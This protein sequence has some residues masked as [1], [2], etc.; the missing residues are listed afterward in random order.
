M[1]ATKGK[2]PASKATAASSAAV[3]T[4]QITFD[5]MMILFAS[6][7]RPYCDVGILK[8]APNHEA[9]LLITKIPEFGAPQTLLHLHG[10][11]F[12]SRMWLDAEKLEAGITLFM[13]HRKPFQRDAHDN[14]M[15]FRWALDFEGEEMYT[16]KTSVDPSGFKTFLRIN[17]G[18]FYTQ[19]ISD[20]ELIKKPWKEPD[21]TIGRVAIKLR[22]EITL[23]D[24]SAYFQNGVN[25]QPVEIKAEQ[26][27]NYGIYVSQVRD[28]SAGHAHTASEDVDAENYNYVIAFDQPYNRKIHF[29]ATTARIDPDARCLIPTMSQSEIT[30]I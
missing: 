17:D 8:Y 16:V 14:P 5:G 18:T 10:E 25:A 23:T 13:D 27:V 4:V 3:S 22:A 1:F 20:N 9:N 19:S 29:G 21:Q 12:E 7:D 11:E 24:E 28:H 6:S 15:D 30:N 26:G 2:R